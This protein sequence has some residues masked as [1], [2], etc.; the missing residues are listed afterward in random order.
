MNSKGKGIITAVIVVLIA[1]AAFCGF[2]YI[3]QRM[4]ASEGI[5]YLDKKEYQKAYEQFDHAAGKFT[6]IFTKQKK[7]VLFYEGEALYQMGEYGKA[8][9]IYDQ[10]IDHGESRAYSLKA[11][12]LAQQKKL[13]KAI[14]VCD[15]GIKEHPDNGE[16]YCTKYAV[17]AKQEKYTQGLKVIETALKQKELENKKEV[18]FARISAYESM[19]DFNT[20]YR[21][22]KAYVKAYP[23]DANG[24]KELT[25][26]LS[27]FVYFAQFSI[28]LFCFCTKKEG[29]SSFLTLIIKLPRNYRVSKNHDFIQKIKFYEK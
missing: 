1:L 18:L 20:A 12:C 14:D 9:E 22:A 5:T 7:D 17:L 28:D 10:L 15:Q 2:G 25:F 13:N 6:L 8:I 19:F 23:K 16:I 24:K 29:L 21:Y 11:Y 4:T 26:L 27:I 3:S